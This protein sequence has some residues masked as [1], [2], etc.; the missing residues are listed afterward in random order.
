MNITSRNYNA[1]TV[2]FPQVANNPFNF[3]FPLVMPDGTYK[4]YFSWFPKDPEGGSNSGWYFYCILPSGIIRYGRISPNAVNWSASPDVGVVFMSS[5]QV[6]GQNDI[7]NTQ[8]Y[9]LYWK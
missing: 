8:M 9:M 2:S 4:F 6:I 5:L 1:Y 7:P 3:N